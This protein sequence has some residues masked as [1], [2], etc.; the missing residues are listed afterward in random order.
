MTKESDLFHELAITPF[1][2]TAQIPVFFFQIRHQQTAVFKITYD[3]RKPIRLQYVAIVTKA[4]P[5][6]YPVR[7]R[8]FS[9]FE[10]RVRRM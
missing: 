10:V 1:Y 5:R 6:A 9:D 8:A 3:W 4:K 2:C 7:A